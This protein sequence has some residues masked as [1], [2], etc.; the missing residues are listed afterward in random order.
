MRCHGWIVTE[1]N[2]FPILASLH[3]ANH[4]VRDGAD[5]I[6]DTDCVAFFKNM[7]DR[8]VKVAINQEIRSESLLSSFD[9]MFK[10]RKSPAY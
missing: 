1:Q 10:Y 7:T 6:A 3:V 5:V 2:V 4:Q 8:V 9:A